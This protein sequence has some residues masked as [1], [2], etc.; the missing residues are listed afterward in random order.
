MKNNYEDMSSSKL[1]DW[2]RRSYSSNNLYD[3]I[4]QLA[5]QTGSEI[6][7]L[8]SLGNPV[9]RSVE[10]YVSKILA[11]T[12]VN[13]TSE[14]QQIVDAIE[15]VYQWS[16]VSG[17]KSSWIR[18]FALLGD[19]FLK[20]RNTQNKV[21]VENINPNFVTS[22][23]LDSRGNTE[24]VRLDIPFAD[25]SGKSFW[26][27]E[28]WSKPD[29]YMSVWEHTLSPEASLDQL[30]D[31]NQY[32]FLSDFGIDFIPI[33]AVQFRDVGKTR[34]QSAVFHTLEKIDELARITTRL[35][36]QVFLSSQE[37]WFIDISNKQSG[38]LTLPQGLSKT[39][40]N[41]AVIEVNGAPVSAIASLPYADILAIIEN[42]AEQL[43]QDLPE[44]RQY[45]ISDT[46]GLSGKS[47]SLLMHP[48]FERAAEAESNLIN[49]LI[50][51]NYAAL[52]IGIYANIFP[53]SLG[54]Y[55]RGDF[56]HSITPTN[57]NI[58]PIDE[59]ATALTG[60][61]S[62]GI[63]LEAAMRL[64]GFSEEDITMT[65][66]AMPVVTSGSAPLQPV[67]GAM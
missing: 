28:F 57:M 51:A 65:T 19:C 12:S 30:G 31:P 13:V 41:M 67:N 9:Q 55:S 6:E 58:T 44:L 53:S 64:S 3:D 7:A 8:K 59:M 35:H 23:N 54:Q 42:L 15:Q 16:N 29:Q 5:L 40:K 50:R 61:T 14:N 1:Y 49:G 18:S 66:E 25:D 45:A 22:I 52:A 4:S 63:P 21:F 38:K 62:A 56:E 27:T 10:F 11:G 24:D 39:Q 36:Q 33:I 2:L 32:Y 48:A 20:I 34:G 47:I 37:K 26:Y 17:K 46:S 43:V 60:L